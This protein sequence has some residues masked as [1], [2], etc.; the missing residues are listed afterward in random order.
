MKQLKKFTFV[1]FATTLVQSLAFAAATTSGADY[2]EVSYD[3]L[4]NQ[5]NAKK[6]SVRKNSYDP[7]D[8]NMIH[9]GFGLVTTANSMNINGTDSTKYQNGF[10]IS[11]G[12]DLFS[13][14]WA[15]EAAL[16]NFG[17]ANSGTETRSL[18][19]FDL[20]LMRRDAL[21]AGAGY[22]LGAGIGSRYMKLSDENISIEDNTPTGVLFGGVD[23]FATKSLSIGMEAGLRTAMVN[24]TADRNA[25]DL[26]VRLDTYF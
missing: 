14:Q 5:L 19:E 12:I 16:R 9:A 4:V 26:M 7:L 6:S 23:M 15:A 2:Q 8:N 24:N 21:T 11:V 22:R 18:R 13:P 1:L 10:Q 25:F 20:K 3:D 17:Q